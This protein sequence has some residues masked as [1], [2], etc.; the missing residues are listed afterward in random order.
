MRT[1]RDFL[2]LLLAGLVALA[3]LSVPAWALPDRIEQAMARGIVG[4]QADGFLGFVNDQ[5]PADAELVRLVNET[6]ILRRQEYTNVAQ[7]T[8]E[9]VANVGT[10]TALRLIQRLPPGQWFKDGNGTWT[11]K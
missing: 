11:R 2:K 8:G 6:N 10:V 4:E 5:R 1:A 3:A 7:R 9:S